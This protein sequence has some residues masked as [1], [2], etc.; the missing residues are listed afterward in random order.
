MTENPV[1]YS[2]NRDYSKQFEWTYELNGDLPSC[3]NKARRDP[4]IGYMNY[5]KSYW[6]K[7]HPELS[8]FTSKNLRDQTSRVEKRKADRETAENSSMLQHYNKCIVNDTDNYVSA[9]Q[10]QNEH[11]KAFTVNTSHKNFTIL[12]H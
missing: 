5:L 3:Y 2:R 7:I 10:Q 9:P 12:T 8:N 6:D 1:S 11:R 4:R